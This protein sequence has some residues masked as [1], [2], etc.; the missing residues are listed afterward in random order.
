MGTD[1]NVLIRACIDHATESETQVSSLQRYV[2]TRLPNLHPSIELPTHNQA[3]TLTHFLSR[4]IDHVPD[5]LEALIEI[6][7]SAGI[8]N[9]ISDIIDIA[10]S[11]FAEPPEPIADHQGLLALVD[12]AYL[13]HRLME[14]V[15][16]R[17]MMKCGIP[18]IPMDMALSNIIVHSL[19]GDEF[20]NQLDLAVLYSIES[21]F[22]QTDML[23][24]TDFRAYIALHKAEGWT[25]ILNEWPCLAGDSSIALTFEDAPKTEP[26][27]LH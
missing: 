3:H 11:Y 8:Y 17:I 27:K 4:Y 24:N 22:E 7:K 26:S 20:A 14:E 23:D 19:L 25:D 12:E 16:D 13:A 15:N 18:L 5:F 21:L 1:K 10:Q 6:S 2:E 9:F